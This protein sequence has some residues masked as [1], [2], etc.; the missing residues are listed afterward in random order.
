MAESLQPQPHAQ[1]SISPSPPRTG[2]SIQAY[3]WKVIVST[4]IANALEWFDFIAYGFFAVVMAKLFFPASNDVTALLAVFAA[5]AIPFAVRPIGAIILG[6][7]AD[8]H[9]RKKTLVLTISLMTLATAIMA[10]VPTYNQIG[11]WAAVIMIAARM[12]QAFSVSGEYGAAVAFLV[13]QDDGRQGFLASWHYS[14]Q[15]MTAVL[16]TGFATVLNATLTPEQV[17]SWGW[18]I[19][20]FFGLLI[21]P[22]G[23][24][25]RSQLRETD[26]FMAAQPSKAPVLEVIAGY[27]SHLALATGVIAVS[28]VTVYMV[29]FMP[30]FAIKQLGLPPSVAFLGSLLAGTIHVVLIPV[31]GLLSDRYDRISL[32]LVASLAVLILAYPLFAFLVSAPSVPAL[33]AVQGTLG[34]LNAINLGCLGALV[35]GMFP[36]RLRTSGLSFANALTQMAIGGTTPIISLWLIEATGHPTAPA[37][38][39]M[40]GAT[41]SVAALTV[42][43]RK[44]RLATADA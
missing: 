36:T 27:R 40:F 35:A 20:F 8:R 11:A 13:E 21:A 41:L 37:F 23:L 9:G 18:R 5:F 42:L 12:L 38:Y 17:V 32:S 33:L 24:Y 22:V 1:A 31:I 2:E 10:T 29:L 43:S 4:S 7:Y 28:A 14:S 19:P 44:R 30:T 3:R 15:S 25:V 16:A 6:A 26:R 34:V 39:L